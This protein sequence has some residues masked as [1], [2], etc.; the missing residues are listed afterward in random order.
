ME[1]L[2]R[3]LLSAYKGLKLHVGSVVPDVPAS[4]LSAYK[5]LKLYS[6]MWDNLRK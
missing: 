5:G 3:G 6:L 4:L 2:Y 1:T